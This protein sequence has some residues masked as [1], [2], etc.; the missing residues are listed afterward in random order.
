MK[1]CHGMG[2]GKFSNHSSYEE[3]VNE[4]LSMQVARFLG[5]TVLLVTYILSK[6]LNKL[7]YFLVQRLKNIYFNL[8][9]S[10]R[11]NMGPT[12]PPIQGVLRSFLWG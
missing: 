6:T 10:S 12:H 9:T 8:F 4:Q 1:Q 11:P 7:K 2:V 3:K 5:E